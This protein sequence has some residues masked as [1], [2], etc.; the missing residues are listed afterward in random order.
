[1]TLLAHLKAA[2]MWVVR[3]WK[4][5][6][7]PLGVLFWAAGKASAKTTVQVQSPALQQ[8]SEL[9]WELATKTD[10][11]L[12][13]FAREK[14]VRDDMI[15]QDYE[16][17]VERLDAKEKMTAEMLQENPEALTDFLKGVGRDQRTKPR[18]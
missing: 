5:F 3:H 18:S 12:A 1:M 14:G 17:V 11:K 13:E 2:G 9:E 8:H 16:K 7:F 10:E 15:N 6:L 4:W